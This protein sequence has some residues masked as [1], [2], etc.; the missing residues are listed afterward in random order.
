MTLHFHPLPN[1]R[2]RSLKL[3]M[4]NTHRK[5]REELNDNTAQERVVV[6]LFHIARQPMNDKHT[7]RERQPW[8]A[9]LP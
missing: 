8:W 3:V 6:P 4:D 1:A 5:L 2:R 9:N 7:E